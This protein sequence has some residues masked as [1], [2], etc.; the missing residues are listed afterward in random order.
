MLPLTASIIPGSC[1][2]QSEAPA[3]ETF[4]LRASVPEGFFH[5]SVEAK[6]IYA[7]PGDG[8]QQAKEYAR[9][10]TSSSRLHICVGLWSRC[11]T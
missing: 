5:R 8:L 3:T 6:S 7:T 2:Q 11:P 10:S 4:G 1:G 9:S